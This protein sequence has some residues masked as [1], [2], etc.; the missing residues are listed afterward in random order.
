MSRLV[1]SAR[2]D[3]A[4][5]YNFRA[6]APYHADSSAEH[7]A[8]ITWEDALATNHGA[9]RT[10]PGAFTASTTGSDFHGNGAITNPGVVV[11][12]LAGASFERSNPSHN[13]AV[14]IPPDS[15]AV[16]D[17]SGAATP[18]GDGR[19]T[20]P[21][22]PASVRPVVTDHVRF[23]PDPSDLVTSGEVSENE[24]AAVSNRIGG[25]VATGLIP[26]PTRGA[27]F[28]LRCGDADSRS[29]SLLQ[30]AQQDRPAMNAPVRPAGYSLTRVP[31]C[32]WHEGRL[33]R[34]PIG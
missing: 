23:T 10:D 15:T 12:R 21:A 16:P 13:P 1:A 14:D 22:D 34:P 25:L 11:N 9:V 29:D 26:S 17:P 8:L 24:D 4:L 7:G 31:L 33:R 5:W 20:K 30:A 27:A 3:G 28:P 19:A 18:R 32:S 6:S 2:E